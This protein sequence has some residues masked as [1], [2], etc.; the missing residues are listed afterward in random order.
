MTFFVIE[1][2]TQLVMAGY[3]YRLDLA[4]NQFII[5]PKCFL[6]VT[7]LCILFVSARTFENNLLS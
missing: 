2:T 3:S 1:F 4:V 5:A 7:F 6:L